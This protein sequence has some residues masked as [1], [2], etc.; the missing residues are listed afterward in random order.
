MQISVSMFLDQYVLA[1]VCV[2]M[3]VRPCVLVRAIYTS[4]FPSRGSSL[5]DSA[6]MAKRA[7]CS[8]ARVLTA[9]RGL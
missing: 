3:R 2:C 7:R 1:C 5:S 6:C 8:H 4:V 9:G